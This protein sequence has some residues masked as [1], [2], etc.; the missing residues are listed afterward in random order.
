MN[1]LEVQSNENHVQSEQDKMPLFN[2]N[3]IPQTSNNVIPQ[4]SNPSPQNSS[5]VELQNTLKSKDE[6]LTPENL[7]PP[8]IDN[9]NSAATENVELHQEKNVAPANSE[10]SV[11]K[12]KSRR[13]SAK[14]KTHSQ[15][16]NVVPLKFFV[17]LEEKARLEIKAKKEGLSLSNYIRVNLGLPPNMIGRKKPG[18]LLSIDLGLDSELE[19]DLDLD[20]ELE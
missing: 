7:K 12:R 3:V 6:K 8:T 18:N 14:K 5:N 16:R 11:V 4:F 13:K 2:Q 9:T 10:K 1:N 20:S 19:I 17:S 15:K